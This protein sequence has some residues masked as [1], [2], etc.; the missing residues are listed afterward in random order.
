MNVLI[1]EETLASI[2][3]QDATSSS[4][5]SL[6]MR[7][8]SKCMDFLSPARLLHLNCACRSDGMEILL[9]FNVQSVLECVVLLFN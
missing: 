2:R 9:D 6:E 4:T 5:P 1:A 3:R 8:A 7:G